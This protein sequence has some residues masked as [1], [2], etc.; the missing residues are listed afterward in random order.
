MHKYPHDMEDERSPKCYHNQSYKGHRLTKETQGKQKPCS[1][2]NS[3]NE[4]CLL[5]YKIDT[6]GHSSRVGVLERKSIV[7]H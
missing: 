7:S 6:E 1:S 2:N 4:S 3:E 5:A